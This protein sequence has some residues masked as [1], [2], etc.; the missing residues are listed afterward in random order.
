MTSAL[1]SLALA[2]VIT[3]SPLS[4]FLRLSPPSPLTCQ[5]SQSSSYIKFISSL[6]YYPHLTSPQHSQPLRYFS[7]PPPSCVIFSK[8]PTAAPTHVTSFHIPRCLIFC[9]A[10]PVKLCFHAVLLGRMSICPL[11]IQL[12]SIFFTTLLFRINTS[13]IPF[14]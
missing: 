9:V 6:L 8:E 4:L 13:P 2:L 12:S 10:V 5:S 1:V 3:S 11:I 7:Q 14:L